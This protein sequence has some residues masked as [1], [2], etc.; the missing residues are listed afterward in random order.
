M[1]GEDWH[2]NESRK[3]EQVSREAQ[4]SA[5]WQNLGWLLLGVEDMQWCPSG[6]GRC[7]SGRGTKCRGSEQ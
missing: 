5:K 6:Q 2:E 3:G 7:M 4:C 1:A